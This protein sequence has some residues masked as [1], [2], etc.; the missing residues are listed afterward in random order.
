MV[1]PN[2]LQGFLWG[3]CLLLWRRERGWERVSER[4]RRKRKR[5]RHVLRKKEK[6]E[7]KKKEKEKKKKKQKQKNKQ[8]TK[9]KNIPDKIKRFS[10]PTTATPIIRISS[11]SSPPPSSTLSP[12]TIFSH[13]KITTTTPTTPTTTTT[14]TTPT[15]NQVR[16]GEK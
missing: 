9:T 5:M 12:S 3:F 8:K 10:F 14:P 15:M 6:E 11:F 1:L 4:M 7:K 2:I 13:H 16:K